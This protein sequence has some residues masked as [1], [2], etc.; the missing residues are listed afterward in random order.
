M[1]IFA[2]VNFLLGIALFIVTAFWGVT[3]NI[4]I[5]EVTHFTL[6]TCLPIKI[7][8]HYYVFDRNS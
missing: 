6:L 5:N 8:I 7:Y 1:R 4:I 2:A 3:G